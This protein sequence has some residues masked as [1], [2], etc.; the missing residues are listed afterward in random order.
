[1][2]RDTNSSRRALAS[3]SPS[4]TAVD[5]L[6]PARVAIAAAFVDALC[7]EELGDDVVR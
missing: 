5:M 6:P 4:K 3:G 1:M 7:G 2:A